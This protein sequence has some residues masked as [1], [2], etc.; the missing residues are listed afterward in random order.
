MKTRYAPNIRAHAAS[1]D[2]ADRP[3]RIARTP[4]GLLVAAC[5][6]GALGCSDQAGTSGQQ[7]QQGT[8]LRLH[9]GMVQGEVVG[10]TRRFLG[11]PFA[12]PPV[13]DLRWRPPA[14][15]APWTDTLAATA[16][17]SS[18]PQRPS[19]LGTPSE[20]E[21][22]LYLNVWTPDPAP[23]EPLPVMVWFHGGGNEFGSAGDDVPLG[24][25]G[26]IFDGRIL[27]ETRAVVV[28]TTNYR[29]GK[30]GFFA[31]PALAAEDPDHPFAGNQGLLDQ[32]A[33]LAWVRDN[34][35]A[36][37]GDPDDVTIFGESAGS[38]DVCLHMVS[39]GSGGLF[40]RAISESG[41]CTTRQDT[42]AEAAAQ[43]EQIAAVVG[44]AGAADELACLRRARVGAL[45]DSGVAVG[46]VVDG[47]FLPDQPRALFAARRFA[48]VPYVIGANADEG[49]I[50]FLGVAPVRTEDEYV[51]ALRERYGER[52]D[53]IAA[54]YPAASFATPQ[55]ALVR[56]VGDSGLVCGTYD[57]A[58]RAAAA[59]ATVYLYNFARWVQIPALQPLDLRALHGAEIAYVF[60]SPPPATD[61]DRALVDAI[62]GYW[63][64]L[65]STG[66]P[67]GDG[68]VRW[69]TYDDATD[70]R[71]NLDVDISAVS[72]F[73]RR[74]CEY[75]WS[76]YDAAFD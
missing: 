2:S 29:L 68:A 36:F 62:Q 50:F 54:V 14:P 59:G 57:S 11:I 66:D 73:R 56:V 6:A 43:A 34:V 74:E 21:D 52:A 20:N 72:G 1:R 64:R 23:A 17:G 44:C 35:A 19:T 3:A 37:G 69:P 13:A 46:P 38:V 51:V 4:A 63:T 60:G 70:L 10:G 42:P 67:N 41:G 47:D 71:L 30:L 5:V 12:A 48:D 32:R 26:K 8:L 31:H 40:H 39:P 9:D 75:W 25:G 61:D 58:R 76:V 7:I 24:L 16:F 27:S 65:A 53:E 33:A 45:L 18:C 28:V 49:T 15:P 55:D 22:C